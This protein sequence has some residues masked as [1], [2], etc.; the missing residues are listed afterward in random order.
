[1]NLESIL[2]RNPYLGSNYVGTYFNTQLRLLTSRSLAE[3]VARRLDLV[4]RPE[5]HSP[6]VQRKSIVQTV[7]DLVTFRWLRSKKPAQ[8]ED[9]SMEQ[10]PDPDTMYAFV[11]LGGLSIAPIEETRLVTLS[12]T[13][14]HP[15]LSADVINALAEEYINYSI[16]MRYE[17]TQ[18]TSEFLSEQIAQLRRDLAAKERELQKYGE[19]KSLLFLKDEENTVVNKFADLSQAYT[20]AQID[21]IQKEAAYRELSNLDVESLPVYVNN[22]VLQN[23]RTEYAQARTEY[24]EKSKVFKPDYP[25]MI[26]LKAK[27]D[28]T[29]NELEKEIRQ[30][31]EIAR[32]EYREAQKKE[33]SMKR[34]VDNQRQDVLLTNNNAILYNSLDIEVQN[35]RNLLNSLV[36]RQNET[37]ISARLKGLKSSNIKIIDRALVPGAPIARNTSRNIM[38]ALLLGLC[39]GVGT[40]FFIEYL[41]N[42]VKDPEEVTRIL[43]LPSLGVVPFVS[44]N[45]TDK[46][47]RYSYYGYGKNKE[48]KTGASDPAYEIELIN[49]LYP[50]IS[51]SEDYRAIRTSILFS[52]ADEAPK[53]ICFSSSLPSEGKTS[54]VANMAV[55]FA[56][57]NKRVLIVDADMRKP[58]QHKV[59][60]LKN[61]KGLSNYLTGKIPLGDAIQSTMIQNLWL[62]T[63]GPHPPN[64][65][66]LLDS[67]KMK[68]LVSSVSVQF[69]IVLVDSPPILAV[70]DPV[71]ISSVSDSTVLIVR[72]GKTTKKALIRAVGEVKKSSVK[73]VGVVYNEVRRSGGNGDYYAPSYHSYMNEYFEERPDDDSQ[74]KAK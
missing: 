44:P 49:H 26:R 41:D 33:E 65:S 51:V 42:T 11:V 35:K 60:Q 24:L 58:R 43:D 30:A 53:V 29:R 14:M 63:S 6:N 5:L 39:I 31:R 66:E 59:F 36:A 61:Q 37:L 20:E 68:E 48:D 21:R 1:M 38:I 56:Q 72:P 15:V 2:N 69:D 46:K 27:L 52:H 40:A 23:L 32:T 12:Y 45:G 74:M 47:N 7:K 4:N 28:S 64:P 71:I 19:E 57:L 73:I 50:N 16:E 55:S 9:V 67:K 25:E 17:A 8:N 22:I 10:M 18:Q 3:R 13:S 70:I 62:M 34:L 54:T